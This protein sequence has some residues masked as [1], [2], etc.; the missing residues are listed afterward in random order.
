MNKNEF[1][2]KKIKRDGNDEN[3][4][5]NKELN[6]EKSISF[7]IIKNNKKQINNIVNE[8]YNKNNIFEKANENI[9]NRDNKPTNNTFNLNI[10]NNNISD[11]KVQMLMNQISNINKIGYFNKLPPSIFEHF[12][13]LQIEQKS[14]ILNLKKFPK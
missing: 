2:N 4:Y 3:G 14:E 12:I 7:N 6:Q 5:K 9:M 1:L 13:F 8:I 11:N 10:K